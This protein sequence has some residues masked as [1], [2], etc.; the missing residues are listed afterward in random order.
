MSPF[1]QTTVRYV[2]AVAAAICATIGRYFL[3][4]VLGATQYPLITFYPAIMAA[5]LYGGLGPGLLA[6]GLCTVAVTPFMHLSG[7]N[8]ADWVG[9][10]IFVVTGVW[11]S[12]FA[13]SLHRA[14]HEAEYRLAER[15]LADER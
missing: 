3:T 9:L 5:A 8:P 15:K 6:T 13:E 12:L 1:P 4:S 10:G 2:V 7:Y 11:I 14:K